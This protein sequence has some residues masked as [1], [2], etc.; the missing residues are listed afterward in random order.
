LN[1]KGPQLQAKDFT[2]DEC[3]E[4]SNKGFAKWF[5]WCEAADHPNESERKKAVPEKPPVPVVKE[6]PAGFEKLEK[7]ADE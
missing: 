5:V 4:L 3:Q 6:R 2:H 7:K 1:G